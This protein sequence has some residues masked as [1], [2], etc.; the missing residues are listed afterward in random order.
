MVENHS[1]LSCALVIKRLRN[2]R[3]QYDPRAKRELVEAGLR[4]GVSVAKLAYQHALN[5][6]LLRKWIVQYQR[7]GGA[8]STTV[9]CVPA[10][11]S[12]FIP[13]VAVSAAA[14]MTVATLRARL[15]NGVEIDT[16]FPA[17]DDLFSLLQMLC[18]L[19][20]SASTRD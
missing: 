6:N 8:A 10:I 13:V 14:P 9:G 1:V 7:E 18:Q 12:A 20:C 11:A 5:A 15:P 16:S 17:C 2:G 4:P 19:P 3:C